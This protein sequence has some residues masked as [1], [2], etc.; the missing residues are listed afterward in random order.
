MK[1]VRIF[2]ASIA[3]VLSIISA[4]SVKAANFK[5]NQVV[6][7]NKTWTVKFTD[8]VTF[9]ELSKSGII[10]KD[11][12]GNIV[13]V[14]LQLNSDG[15]TIL[16]SPPSDG[17]KSGESYTLTLNDNI[18][19][20][21]SKKLAHNV[22]VNF[23]ISKDLQ[24]E[25]VLGNTAGNS[26]NGGLLA[27]TDNYIYFLN[28]KYWDA[29]D[30]YRMD[31]SEQNIVKM[32]KND[33][34]EIGNISFIN[35]TIY[36]EKYYEN[37]P[38]YDY[39]TNNTVKK[40]IT[41][42]YTLSS[43]GATST[44]T[45]SNIDEYIVTD[46]NIYYINAGDDYKLYKSDLTGNNKVKLIDT[47]I[48]Y[49][50]ISGQNII[51]STKE[52]DVKKAI[53]KT[54][55]GKVYK[56]DLDGSNNTL[57]TENIGYCLNTVGNY[58]Y[59][60][61]HSDNNKIYKVSLDGKE[62]TK[63]CNDSAETINVSNGWIYYCNDSKPITISVGYTLETT[64]SVGTL[65]KIKTDGTGSEKLNDSYS[66]DIN[67]GADSVYYH[68]Y[69]DNGS[70]NADIRTKIKKDGSNDISLS[71]FVENTSS[72]STEDTNNNNNT[73]TTTTGD[74]TGNNT[75][76]TTDNI[77][78]LIKLTDDC[79]IVTK[80]S[81]NNIDKIALN[82]DKIPSSIKQSVTGVQLIS[83]DELDEEGAPYMLQGVT[84]NELYFNSGINDIFSSEGEESILHM[85]VGLTDAAG[86][87]LAYY[88]N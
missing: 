48:S 44:K 53:V 17:Y 79:V 22:N 70:M 45:L 13:P 32:N 59:Y 6:S 33:L 77:D 56:A 68:K 47:Q 55:A 37:N 43:D 83:M 75:G 28:S 57:L 26:V 81:N 34:G 25:T 87:T 9:D 20:I 18:R 72:S 52:Q 3:I 14:S 12:N 10:I 11:S 29:A 30:I 2:T 63:V 4:S 61:N 27:E 85:V 5:D 24:K 69:F 41:N 1:R 51:Y 38:D 16:V 88:T 54:S 74:D 8:Q 84:P 66:R 46:N 19:N 23:S 15:K 62:S 60:I 76:D 7:S 35:N 49:F 73:T 58:V 50:N 39:K 82:F 86:N 67:V 78:G 36:Y 40:Y 31:K 80:D 64:A 71:E 21:K 42:L 65:Y